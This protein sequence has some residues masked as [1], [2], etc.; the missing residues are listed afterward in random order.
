MN[1]YETSIHALRSYKTIELNIEKNL[2]FFLDKHST[3]EGTWGYLELNSGAVDFVFL[4]GDGN[5]LSSY[6]INSN[7]PTLLIPPAL[8]HKIVLKN[9]EFNATL[10]FF[11]QPHRY[12]EKKY[13]LRP[14]HHDLRYVYQTY[15]QDKGK[16]SMLDIGCGSGRNLLYFAMSGHQVTGIDI[17]ENAIQN[18]HSIA[19][20]EQLSNIKLKIHDLNQRLPTFDQ[21]F[22]FLYSTVTLQFLNKMHIHPLLTQ[23]QAHTTIGGMN[24]LVFP[25]KSEPYY[26]PETF[27][28][29]AEP[30]ELYHFYQDSGW[31]ILEYSEKVG[32]LHKQDE[33]GKPKQGIF[34]LLLAQR[35]L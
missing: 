26:Y 13:R 6:S 4:D 15:L 28:Y 18:I 19:E 17:N 7:H 11:C 30:G 1:Q 22:D 9:T 16:M 24:F 20:K 29:L 32:Q 25:I 5:K 34:G 35:Y 2:Q 27:T 8:W 12:F 31:S 33:T 21:P 23:L 14:I 3:K 10:Q